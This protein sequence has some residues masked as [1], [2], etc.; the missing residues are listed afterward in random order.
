M[1]PDAVNPAAGD[2]QVMPDA[3]PAEGEQAMPAEGENMGG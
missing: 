1:E 3:A 2:D